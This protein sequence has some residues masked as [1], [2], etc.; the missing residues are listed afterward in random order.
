MLYRNFTMVWWASCPRSKRKLGG[1]FV[2][3]RHL[4]IFSNINRKL[5]GWNLF[6]TLICIIVDVNFY[7]VLV[8]KITEL[9]TPVVSGKRLGSRRVEDSKLDFFNCA[10][11]AWCGKYVS[12]FERNKCINVVKFYHFCNL[13]IWNTVCCIWKSAE[14]N[15]TWKGISLI[16]RLTFFFLFFTN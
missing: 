10:S 5:T 3:V 12:S 2:K 14:L 9:E 4:W 1:R 15:Y 7:E 13:N 11:W 16:W 6:H 8:K